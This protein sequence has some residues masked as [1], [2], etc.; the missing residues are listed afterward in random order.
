MTAAPTSPR[1]SSGSFIIPAPLVPGSLIAIASPASIVDPTYVIR[2]AEALTSSGFRVRIMPHAL[3]CAGSF[4]GNRYQRL[5]DFTEAFSDPEVR[6]I[7]CS[8]GGYGCIQLIGELDSL[9]LRDDPKWLIGFSDVTA[10]HALMFRHGIASIHASMAKSLA[11]HPLDAEPNR[12]LLRILRGDLAHDPVRAAISPDSGPR[13]VIGGN[14]ALLQ[15]LIGTPFDMMS[16]AIERAKS[17][18]APDASNADI[19]LFIEDISEPLYRVNRMLWQMKLAG[20]FD[21]ISRL[22]VGQFT[23]YRPDANYTD[24][25][26]MIRDFFADTDIPVT[27]DAPI[28]HTDSNRPILL[29]PVMRPQTS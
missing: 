26:A 18:S 11:L 2:A 17:T 28:G 27:F 21:N 1:R 20:W 4:A 14:M 29:G 6:A 7:L 8:R 3:G 22:V 16:N 12:S 13:I 9:P 25:N 19:V 10:L 24:A 15:A 5:A 23:N